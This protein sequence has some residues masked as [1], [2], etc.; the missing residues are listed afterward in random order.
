MDLTAQM[1]KPSDFKVKAGDAGDVRRPWQTPRIILGELS[2]AETGAGV[3]TD[4]G[5]GGITH[6]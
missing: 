6:S 1:E 2:E 4:A 3:T 5:G